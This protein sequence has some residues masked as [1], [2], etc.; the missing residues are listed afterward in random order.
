M[1]Q[2]T[3]VYHLGPL[4]FLGTLYTQE[5]T[6]RPLVL[7]APAWHGQDHFARDK[8]KV[9]AELGYVGLAL[10]LY[11]EGKQ[12]QTAEEAA[13]LMHPL[14][15]DRKTLRQRMIAALEAGRNLDFVDRARV[16]AIGFCFGGLCVLELFRSGAPVKGVVS[17]H[18]LLGDKL[19]GQS[20]KT[21]P[22][23]P[24][25]GALLVLDG[26]EDP[27]VP[28]SDL[29]NLKKEMSEAG[30]DWEID[31]YGHAV[32][33]FTNPE[34]HDK[35]A[36]LAYDERASKRAFNKMEVFLKEIFK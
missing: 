30:A 1:I 36:G 14:F 17:F 25:R 21:E 22:T 20:A 15:L 27:M 5:K 13:A 3:L 24:L 34:V 35:N 23:Q 18:G 2:E 11:G 16:G 12:V 33:A 10:D 8:A 31:I 9:L 7:V 32:H 26:A 19:G 6:L 29:E 4:K 28:W